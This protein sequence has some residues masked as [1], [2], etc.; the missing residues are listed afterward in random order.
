MIKEQLQK[1]ANTKL[2]HSSRLQRRFAACHQLTVHPKLLCEHH[3]EH[4]CTQRSLTRPAYQHFATLF[5]TLPL[6]TNTL[7]SGGLCRK[8][9]EALKILGVQ[10]RLPRLLRC[11]KDR[12]KDLAV[13]ISGNDNQGWLLALASLKL[14]LAAR[15]KKRPITSPQNGGHK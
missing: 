10:H 6:E 1:P 7:K 8:A 15:L 5:S 11:Y 9:L 12:S 2:I 3:S 4:K 14:S 13:N